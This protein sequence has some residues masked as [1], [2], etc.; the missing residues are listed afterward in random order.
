MA[1][2]ETSTHYCGAPIRFNDETNQ[3]S[4]RREAVDLTPD[5]V[6]DARRYLDYDD[7]GNLLG[8]LRGRY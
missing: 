7:I 5:Q 3:L 4:H 6:G 8:M 1:I 2:Y